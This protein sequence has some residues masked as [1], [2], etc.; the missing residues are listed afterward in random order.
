MDVGQGGRGACDQ[1]PGGTGRAQWAST[2]GGLKE[3]KKKTQVIKKRGGLTKARTNSRG[4]LPSAKK[5]EKTYAR[6]RHHKD[7]K[8]KQS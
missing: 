3:K 2:P 8:N 4:V 6:G 7:N 5:K 1:R